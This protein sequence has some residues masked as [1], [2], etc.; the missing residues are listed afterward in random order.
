MRK[1]FLMLV[2]VM[3][4]GAVTAQTQKG[5]SGQDSIVGKKEVKLHKEVFYKIRE[6]DNT[7]E[8]SASVVLREVAEFM[9][10]YADTRVTLTGYADK[11]TGNPTLNVMYAMNRATKFKNDLISKFGIDPSR[12]VA[13]SRG[14]REQPFADNDKNRCVIVDGVGY[15]L[16]FAKKPSADEMAELQRLKAQLEK[17]RRYREELERQAALAKKHDTIYV[18]TTDTLWMVR[19]L[20]EER[21]FGLNKEHR[22][23]NWFVT[24]A[25]GPSIYQGDHNR[26]SKWGDRLYFSGD[27]SIGKWIFPALGVRAGVNLDN[28]HMQYNGAPTWH[29]T[30]PYE[31]RPWLNKM[32]FNAWNFHVEALLNL[33]SFMWRPYTKRIYSLIPYVGVS[34]IAVW[35]D[36]FQYSLALNAGILNSFRI[37][38][39]FDLN[40]DIRVKSFSDELNAFSQGRHHD[41]IGSV[42]IGATWHFT[43]RGF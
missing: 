18:H 15:E 11:G 14:D 25:V 30:G 5:K 35:D 27:I 7:S 19:E 3:L 8:N 33:S 28:V 10:K 13:D 2:A 42:S 23:Y 37:S 29:Y 24:A 36:N 12:I 40:L 22:W 38:E 43:K 21:P 32:K 34:R 1:V 9:K 6:S 31:P 26:D 16:I 39:H 4:T 17:E 20:K 41:G